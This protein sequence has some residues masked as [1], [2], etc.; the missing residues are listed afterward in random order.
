MALVYA[1][2]VKETVTTTGTSSFAITG[3]AATG[4]RTFASAMSNNDTCR[5][6]CVDTTAGTWEVGTGTYDSANAL[7]SRDTVHASSNAGAKIAFASGS[8]DL[9][10]T[11]A[12]YDLNTIMTAINATNN[13]VQV[14]G[15]KSADF[16]VDASSGAY[17]TVTTGAACNMS[18]TAQGATIRRLTVAIT[19]GATP[20]TV[21]LKAAD[22]NVISAG[23]LLS[24]GDSLPNSGANTTD[25][26]VFEWNGTKWETLDARY[27]V[28]A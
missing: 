14:L 25:V 7:L 24:S 20:Y 9:F 1:D 19:Q 3:T 28:K 27:D 5:Y 15:T 10:I 16:S 21:T 23:S 18:L 8:K 6:C 22:A 13:S 4:Y 17:A 2:R 12:G 26:F 11:V